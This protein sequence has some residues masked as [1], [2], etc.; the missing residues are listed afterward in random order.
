MSTTSG[1]FTESTVQILKRAKVCNEV[2]GRKFIRYNG[3]ARP[4]TSFGEISKTDVD[5]A[6]RVWSSVSGDL[7]AGCQVTMTEAVRYS[8]A[9]VPARSRTD[10]RLG[11]SELGDDADG[12]T[13]RESVIASKDSAFRSK[14]NGRTLEAYRMAYLR[15]YVSFCVLRGTRL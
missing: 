5:A 2:G 14:V 3:P 9:V 15:F 6:K 13:W 8:Y 12:K 4:V 7:P 11:F 1:G 10:R